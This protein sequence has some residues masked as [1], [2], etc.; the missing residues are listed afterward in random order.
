[1][2]DHFDQSTIPAAQR[3]TNVNEVIACLAADKAGRCGLVMTRKNPELTEDEGVIP[4]DATRL[5][6]VTDRIRLYEG[7]FLRF[8]TFHATNRIDDGNN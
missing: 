5:A 4:L 7:K 3:N 6:K 2:Y 8:M 1:V